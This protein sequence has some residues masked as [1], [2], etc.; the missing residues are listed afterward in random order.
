[1][2]ASIAEWPVAGAI[3]MSVSADLE[4][5]RPI[6]FDRRTAPGSSR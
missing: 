2:L 4:L 1:M 5:A 6:C 3:L